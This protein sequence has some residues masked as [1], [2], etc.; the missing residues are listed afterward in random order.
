MNDN[1]E[2]RDAWTIHWKTQRTVD[3]SASLLGIWLRRKR[4]DII[5]TII[6]NLDREYSVIDL[7]CGAGTTLRLFRDMGFNNSVGIDFVQD[8][9]TRCEEV[10]FVQGKDVFI[11]DARETTFPDRYFDVVFSEGLWEHFSD[12]H[13]HIVEAARICRKYIIVIQPNHYS[14]VGW[15]MFAGWKLFA[16]S[17]GG[18]KEYSFRLSYFEEELKKQGFRQIYVTSVLGEQA[19]LVFRRE[20]KS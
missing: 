17:K 20:G 8:S 7:G 6:S 10:G 19:I 2:V 18:I 15:L 9:L 11:M 16:S 3:S 12:P 14:L 13:N 5:R 1:T 4:L